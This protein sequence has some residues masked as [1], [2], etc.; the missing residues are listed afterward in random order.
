MMKDPLVF[1]T[2]AEKFNPYRWRDDTHRV[3]G[4]AKAPTPAQMLLIFNLNF[5]SGSSK[6]LGRELAMIELMML[7]QAVSLRA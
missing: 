6:C 7:V 5:G 1:G 4:D 3:P 2:D